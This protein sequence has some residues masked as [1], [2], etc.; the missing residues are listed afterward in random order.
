M[1]VE[2]YLKIEEEELNPK[3]YDMPVHKTSVI[4]KHL[5]IKIQK[6]VINTM[7]NYQQKYTNTLITNKLHNQ[8]M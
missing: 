7:N 6:K 8:Y 5:H 3:N 1:Y 2:K 4:P